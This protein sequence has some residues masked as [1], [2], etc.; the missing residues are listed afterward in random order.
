MP[1]ILLTPNR[2]LSNEQRL[3]CQA[4]IWRIHL[5]AM[6]AIGIRDELPPPL[7]TILEDF[8]NYNCILFIIDFA[9]SGCI[10]KKSEHGPVNHVAC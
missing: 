7:D 9:G 6:N 3:A 1:D 4:Y 2:S 8:R 10:S 5:L